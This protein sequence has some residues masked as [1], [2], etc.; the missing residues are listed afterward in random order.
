MTKRRNAEGMKG[1]TIYENWKAA[2]AGEPSRGAVEFPIFTDAHITGEISDGYGPYRFL[3][4]L[5]FPIAYAVA[6]PAIMVRVENHLAGPVAKMADST[7]DTLYHG[8]WLQEE[9]AALVSLCMGIRAQTGGITREFEPDRNPRGRPETPKQPPPSIIPNPHGARMIPE[10]IGTHLLNEELKPLVDLPALRPAEVVELVRAARLYAQAM[11][12]AESAPELS[13][14]LFVSAVETGASF[15]KS[16][17]A[18]PVETLWLAQPKIVETL[19]AGCSAAVVTEVA[20]QL[21]EILGATKAFLTFTREHIPDPP[22][23]RPPAWAQTSW[24]PSDLANTLGKI[25]TYRSRALHGGKPFPA[26]MCMPPMRV[27]ERTGAPAERPY[28]IKMFTLGGT[29]T[30]DDVPINLHA[31]AYVVRGV[32]LKWWRS[33]AQGNPRDTSSRNASNLSGNSWKS[34]HLFSVSWPMHQS[35]EPSDARPRQAKCGFS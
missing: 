22:A 32:L 1:L 8:G 2:I 35:G 12:V 26:P 14:L 5:A 6:R 28:G 21:V 23:A 3:N 34:T 29:W 16:S 15:T 4:L 25:Y 10:A 11:W 18:D 30:Q 31:F 33:M 7:D 17:A 24:T 20:S 9:I 27:T 13:W 19:Q